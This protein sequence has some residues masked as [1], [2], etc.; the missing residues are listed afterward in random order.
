MSIFREIA[1]RLAQDER[2]L[3]DRRRDGRM[4]PGGISP[5]DIPEIVDSSN[6]CGINCYPGCPKSPCYEKAVFISL[7]G[8]LKGRWR[9]HLSFDDALEKIVKHCGGR[10]STITKQIGLITDTWDAKSFDS[11][12]Q[13]LI[14]FKRSG[15]MIEV[16]LIA[17]GMVSEINLTRL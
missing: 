3:E 9:G 4:E 17:P 7:S 2:V 14:N 10:C 5:T 13:N 11:W 8:G 12:R 15:I 1:R 16:Y 6:G